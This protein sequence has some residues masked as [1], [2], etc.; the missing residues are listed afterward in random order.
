MESGKCTE[1]HRMTETQRRADSPQQRWMFL[2]TARGAGTRRA[3]NCGKFWGPRRAARRPGAPT[4]SIGA[5][6][7]PWRRAGPTSQRAAWTL[8]APGPQIHTPSSPKT[9]TV[10]KPGPQIHT[11]GTPTVSTKYPISTPTFSRKSLSEHR[12]LRSQLFQVFKCQLSTSQ[13]AA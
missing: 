10:A 13:G 3:A 2:G 12:F 6:K 9:S 8:S 11:G 5:P 7:K 1:N 4:S